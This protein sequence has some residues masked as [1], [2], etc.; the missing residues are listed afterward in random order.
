MQALSRVF[1][2][3]EVLA[4]AIG[5][6]EDLCG[7]H[8]GIAGRIAAIAGQAFGAAS[9]RCIRCADE[10]CARCVDARTAGTITRDCGN[11]ARGPEVPRYEYQHDRLDPSVLVSGSEL[12]RVPF[13]RT[14]LV[15]APASADVP[16]D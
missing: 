13:R 5:V 12:L 16:V 14:V 8:L 1:T 3:R 11:A 6:P 9:V 2:S 10:V 4:M 7:C 15:V